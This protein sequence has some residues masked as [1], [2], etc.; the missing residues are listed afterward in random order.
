M[1][2]LKQYV[3]FVMDNDTYFGFYFDFCNAISI[4]AY[5]LI[6]AGVLFGVCTRALHSGASKPGA[7]HGVSLD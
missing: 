6:L 7:S 3:N 4:T 5:E 1:L 2:R